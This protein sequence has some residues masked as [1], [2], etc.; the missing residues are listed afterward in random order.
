MSNFAKLLDLH[1]KLNALTTAEREELFATFTEP[2]APVPAVEAA[3][4]AAKPRTVKA[5]KEA[6]KVRAARGES[7]GAR[8]VETALKHGPSTAVQVAGLLGVADKKALQAIRTAL[9]A[10]ARKGRLVAI[11]GEYGTEY[12]S[13]FRNWSEST[14]PRVEHDEL[15]PAPIN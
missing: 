14:E 10:A 4:K 3:P 7:I 5:T 13:A 9:T 2:A 12:G 6:P 15:E 1:A 8:A 11:K